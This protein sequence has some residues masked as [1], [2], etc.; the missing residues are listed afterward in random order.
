[1][2]ENVCRLPANNV[3]TVLSVH[4]VFLME[5][6]RMDKMRTRKCLPSICWYSDENSEFRNEDNTPF[7]FLFFNITI[8]NKKRTLKKN[9][10]ETFF[11]M[12]N[13][14][15]FVWKEIIRRKFIGEKKL[16]FV[17]WSDSITRLSRNVLLTFTRQIN[18]HYIFIE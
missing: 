13:R 14:L 16:K 4:I 6:K 15:F 3:C 9:F 10:I 18:R 2:P 8:Q 17:F 11:K 1:M 12:F 5:I 7:F